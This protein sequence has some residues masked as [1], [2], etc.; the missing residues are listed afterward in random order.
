MNMPEN[1]TQ[2]R[3]GIEAYSWLARRL[4]SETASTSIKLRA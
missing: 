4:F 2:Y 3:A 1:G